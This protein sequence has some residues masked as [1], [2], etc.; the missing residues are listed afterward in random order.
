MFASLLEAINGFLYYPL[1]IIVLAV[2]GIY[3]S[4][5][6]KFVQIRMV[7]EAIRALMEKP[8]DDNGVSSFQ[9]LIVST[10]SRV[11][12]GNIVGVSTAIVLGGP[13]AAFW[14][15]L[16]AIIGAATAFIE[17][18]LAQIYKRK[19]KETGESYGGPAY[20]I[21]SALKNRG[22]ASLFALFLILTYAFGF[23]LLASYNLQSTFAVYD[24]YHPSTTPYII[25][26]ILAAIVA[27]AIFG[28]GKRIVRITEIIVP[29]MGIAYVLMSIIVLAM[30]IDLLPNAIRL[31][32]EDAF[33]ARSFGGGLAG[34]AMIYGIKR[35][36]YSNEAGVGSA[37]NA[38]ASAGVSHP[39]KQG[40]VQFMSVYIDTLLI[41][42]AT[43]MMC[44]VTDVQPTEELAGAPFIQE[45]LAQNFGSIGPSFITIAM[46]LFSF[47]TLLGNLYYCEPALTFLNKNKRPSKNFILI[48]NIICVAVIFIGALVPMDMAWTIADILM[49]GMALINI[50]V[51]LL[52]GNAAIK[53]VADYNEQ[54]KAGKEPVFK[55]S[56]VGLDPN[57]LDYW[58]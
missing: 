13:G 36:L 41:C 24:F 31:I 17:S 56:K 43:A 5:R 27:Y 37:P 23:N 4:F 19:D 51:C 52:I 39:V 49:A 15:W 2:A 20:Y 26:A 9:A 18:T 50:P 30:N 22:I 29:V 33:S 46:I 58:G 38:A 25:G 40:L 48:F 7:P 10:A 6:T 1:L 21:E 45:V 11:G 53:A 47:T 57:E 44:I 34:S 8:E 54:R 42:T 35:G 12:T 3:F 55:A 28:G 14:M 16:L 32:F